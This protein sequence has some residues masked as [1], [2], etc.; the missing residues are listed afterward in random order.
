MKGQIAFDLRDS[1]ASLD[2]FMD[3][4]PKQ[5]GVPYGN[6]DPYFPSQFKLDRHYMAMISQQIFAH[7]TT[8]VLSCHVQKFVAIGSF[9]FEWEQNENHAT[10]ELWWKMSVEWIHSSSTT[11][12]AYISAQW[13]LLKICV[14]IMQTLVAT[15]ISC[16]SWK[17]WY[18]IIFYGI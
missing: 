15:L 18:H 14:V 1:G 11:W 4:V 16:P 2:A 3:V 12:A 8:A 17:W 9:E 10:F 13:K 6:R 7:A 5:V